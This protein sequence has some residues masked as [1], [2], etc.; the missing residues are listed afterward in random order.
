MEFPPGISHVLAG[1]QG[2]VGCDRKG[3]FAEKIRI[4]SGTAYPD[5][6]PLTPAFT[7]LSNQK[8]KKTI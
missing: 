7:R 1:W 6:R 2:K 5:V 8:K 4:R 3:T